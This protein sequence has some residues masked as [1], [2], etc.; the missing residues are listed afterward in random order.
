M[1]YSALIFISIASL[2][3]ASVTD[4]APNHTK[5]RPVKALTPEL[6]TGDYVWH[7]EVSPAGPVVVFVSLP[8]KCY[9]SI[10]MVC[11]SDGRR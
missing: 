7:P 9:T 5:G 10:A 4:A 11:A 6:K 3:A 2:L 1:K 8:T